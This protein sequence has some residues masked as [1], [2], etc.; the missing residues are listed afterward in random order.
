MGLDELEGQIF[1]E[2]YQV[3]EDAEKMKE[4]E[5]KFV[6][7]INKRMAL[8]AQRQGGEAVDIVIEKRKENNFKKA[9]KLRADILK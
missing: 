9:K 3:E 4:L 8:A 1:E 5:T 6:N 7:K 2:H